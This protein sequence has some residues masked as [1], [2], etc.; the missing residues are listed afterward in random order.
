MKRL[1]TL[2][3]FFTLIGT[4]SQAQI[5]RIIGDSLALGFKPNAKINLEGK[6][7]LKRVDAGTGTDSILVISDGV[8]KKSIPVGGKANLVGDNTFT[9]DYNNFMGNVSALGNVSIEGD[10]HITGGLTAMTMIEAFDGINL[11]NSKIEGLATPTAATD[12]TNKNYVDNGLANKENLSNKV[13]NLSGA[14]NT[15]YPTSLAVANAIASIA[16]GVQYQGLWDASTNTPTLPTASSGNNGWFYIVA[17]SG[18]YSSESYVVGDW[19]MSD[20]SA[21]GK[22]PM[23]GLVANKADVDG[24]NAT[25]TWGIDISGSAEKWSGEQYSAS[26]SEANLSAMMGY[27]S[28]T[29]KW[30]Y[31]TQTPV[32]NW[33]GLGS[34]AYQ[35]SS[36]FQAALGYTPYNPASYPVNAGGET[37]QSV[38]DRGNVITKSITSAEPDYLRLRNEQAD[39]FAFGIGVHSS[40]YAYLQ[41][42]IEG[43]SY[44]GAISMNPNGGNVGIGTTNPTAKL[45]VDGTLYVENTSEFNG[46]VTINSGLTVNSY[47]DVLNHNIINVDDPVNDQDAATKGYV[48]SKIPSINVLSGTYVLP[49]NIT[50]SPNSA[51]GITL[52]IPGTQIGDPSTGGI[53]FLASSDEWVVWSY[54]LNGSATVYVR[55]MTSSSKTISAGSVVKVKVFK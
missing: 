5:Q 34:A 55:N 36:A 24:S 31:Y 46:D 14:S 47:I 23:S 18:S 38:T 26:G 48:D 54:T 4:E 10:T 52:I 13:T 21:W 51:A 30:T 12:A 43:V 53:D 45:H 28:I 42:S 1:L 33:L 7:Y 2:I 22:V 41:G 25:G 11:Y 6:I 16:S 50:V 44:N 49:S 37:L 3:L 39:P 9:G 15:T 17:T 27:N 32:R 8:V 35:P 20:G 40:G 29:N 19:V